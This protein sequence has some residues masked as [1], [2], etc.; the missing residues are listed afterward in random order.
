M[1]FRK[2]H[3]T[4]VRLKFYWGPDSP[5]PLGRVNA[6]SLALRE[7]SLRTSALCLSIPH[8]LSLY[9]HIF[10]LTK[11]LLESK[12]L[13]LCEVSPGWRGFNQSDCAFR[14]E[15][16]VNLLQAS[17]ASILIDRISVA[18]ERRDDAI[19]ATEF[20]AQRKFAPNFSALIS[21]V[22]VVRIMGLRQ[23]EL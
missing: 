10:K 19:K 17:A 9:R 2:V 14:S 8:R 23:S 21:S 22:I 6:P 20:S 4:F 5:N 7:N 16:M 1:R 12:I 3:R 11:Y 13:Y 18:E 15:T